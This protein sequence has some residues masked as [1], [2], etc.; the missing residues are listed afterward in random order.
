MPDDFGVFFYESSNNLSI[1]LVSN[2]CNIIW[3]HKIVFIF[4]SKNGKSFEIVLEKLNSIENA[5][6]KLNGSSNNNTYTLL[7]DAEINISVFTDVYRF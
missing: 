4:Y 3:L 7:P 5:I 1:V 6:G 2:Y